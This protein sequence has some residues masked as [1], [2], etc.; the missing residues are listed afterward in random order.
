MDMDS[1]RSRAKLIKRRSIST[2][3][4]PK[5][6][7]PGGA[8]DCLKKSNSFYGKRAT[9]QT[10]PSA[11][12]PNDDIFAY[13]SDVSDEVN[14]QS[15]CGGLL[16]LGLSGAQLKRDMEKRRKRMTIHLH[17]SQLLIP[18]NLCQHLHQ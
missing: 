14:D 2:S 6:T 4:H 7:A 10:L 5:Q 9:L 3:S 18:R 13:D 16:G 11:T 1:N 8:Y 15:D 12:A 17:V